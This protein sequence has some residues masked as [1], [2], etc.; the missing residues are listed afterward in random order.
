M[1]TYFST[2]YVHNNTRTSICLPILVL[3]INSDI[4]YIIIIGTLFYVY[5][6][7]SEL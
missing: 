6:K 2:T 5:K 3:W 4:L 7:P 1:T